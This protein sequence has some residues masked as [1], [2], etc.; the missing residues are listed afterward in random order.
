M[1]RR[2][3][4]LGASIAMIAMMASASAAQQPAAQ[5]LSTRRCP[6]INGF[7]LSVSGLD[8]NQRPRLTLDT[9]TTLDTTFVLNIAERRWQEARMIASLEAGIGDTSRANWYACT[10]VSIAMRDVSLVL[11]AVH[12]QIRY[13]VD[14]TPL[15]NI[16]RL[17]APGAPPRR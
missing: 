3:H 4:R 14:L 8:T 6:A 5:T 12:G 11:R 16:R 13:K 9:Q 17:T 10:G 7:R 1:R 2:S 15:R